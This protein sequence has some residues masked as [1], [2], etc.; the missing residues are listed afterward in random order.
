MDLTQ[1]SHLATIFFFFLDQLVFVV[2][3]RIK[4]TLR[5]RQVYFRLKVVFMAML[6]LTCLAL[7][8]LVG[9]LLLF[10][11]VHGFVLNRVLIL[12]GWFFV[13]IIYILDH[14]FW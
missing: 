3:R 2:F 6:G 5:K 1:D 12:L 9:R 4:L 10:G 13:F 8:D 11:S 7:G 14:Y